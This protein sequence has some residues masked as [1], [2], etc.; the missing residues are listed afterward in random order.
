MSPENARIHLPLCPS[1]QPSMESSVVFGV[2]G[3]AGDP[4]L[5]SYLAMPLP[6]TE[7]VLALA[8]PV[9]PTEIMR[10]AAPC[11]GHGCRHFD[12]SN[13]RLATRVVQLLP[14]VVDG[15]PPCPLR[16]KCRW[17]QQEGKAACVRCPQ[18]IS[19]NVDPSDL[20]R[21]VSDGEGPAA[22][23]V[24]ARATINASLA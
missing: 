11:A 17:W 18:V 24:E 8:G 3:E 13:C 16:P 20:I 22:P 21:L 4:P 2:F 19:E 6:V 12:G 1:A 5:L 14:P 15:L 7:Q 23:R 10:F 9:T